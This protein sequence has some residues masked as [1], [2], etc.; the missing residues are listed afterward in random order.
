MKIAVLLVPFLFS[1]NMAW[2]FQQK[3]PPNPLQ[4]KVERKLYVGN[5]SVEA[6]MSYRH[7]VELE[8]TRKP[9][10][11][12]AHEAIEAQINHLFGPM[13][14]AKKQ[15]AVPKG[16]HEIAVLAI[17]KKEGVKGIYT[18]EYT[19]EGTIV[20]QVP[21]GGLSATYPIVLPTNPGKVYEASAVKVGDDLAYPCTDEHY[22]SEGD[23]WYFWD[24]TKTGCPLVQGKDY[25]RLE[26]KVK[27]HPN[28]R[29]SYPKYS[30]L[31]DT[32]N[33]IKISLL[34]GMDE[35]ENGRNPLRSKDTNAK[36]Y[37]TIADSLETLGFSRRKLPKEEIAAVSQKAKGVAP[38]VEE[39]LKNEKKS[40]I[41]VQLFFGPSGIG[42]ESSH[43]HYFFKDA[44]E[45]SAVMIYDG[46][47]GL[48]GHLDLASIEETEGFKITPPV[49][50]DQ[51][52]F[53]N[54][55]SSY[56]YYNSMFFNRKSTEGDPRGIQKLDILTNGLATYFYVMHNTNM[57]LIK[58]ISTWASG[59]G[60]VSYQAIAK[61]IDSG[62][63]FG[64]NG[65]EDNPTK[66]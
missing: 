41:K 21:K 16:D 10:A 24:P 19:Y 64:V 37:V 39:F 28:T 38:Y 60:G 8:A 5:G 7:T 34:M 40:K 22:Q 11:A 13:G 65:D 30:T 46:H 14:E 61:K 55:C 1:L 59:K 31:A 17:A 43:F 52:Y 32:N 49:E 47:S 42:E 9:S 15:K 2:A 6:T 18:V 3:I 63:L 12:K 36:N 35:P 27:E 45:N 53:F 33:E 4:K 58:A 56:S 26:A 48:G 54:S 66:L 51:I 50:R 57:E 44:V 25:V 20:V 23:F 29:I 62:N